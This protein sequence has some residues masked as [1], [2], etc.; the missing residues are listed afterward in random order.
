MIAAI[1][2]P[3]LFL[4]FLYLTMKE[5]KK[6]IQLWTNIGNIREE[7][8]IKGKIVQIYTSKYT[9]IGKYEVLEATLLIKTNNGTI[10]AKKKMPITSDFQPPYF[11]VNTTIYCYGSYIRQHFIFNRYHLEI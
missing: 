8:V 3:I 10:K 6:R 1:V 5:R 7:S 9:Y 4:Y 11:E 2:I